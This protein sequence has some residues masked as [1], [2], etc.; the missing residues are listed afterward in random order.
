ME[1]VFPRPSCFFSV[2]VLIWHLIMILLTAWLAVF[3]AQLQLPAATACYVFCAQITVAALTEGCK[4]QF[5]HCCNYHSHSRSEP[6]SVSTWNWSLFIK[7]SFFYY[8]ENC[9][10]DFSQDADPEFLIIMPNMWSVPSD[11]HHTNVLVITQS[12]P[13]LQDIIL[14]LPFWPG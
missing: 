1:A 10:Q 14:C 5:C 11:S 7:K 6:N 4:Q 3:A 2:T 8:P 12:A 9:H 13:L